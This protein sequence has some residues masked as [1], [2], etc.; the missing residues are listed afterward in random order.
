MYSVYYIYC[1]LCTCGRDGGREKQ[2]IEWDLTP[3]MLNGQFLWKVCG[4]FHMWMCASALSNK[5]TANQYL[6]SRKWLAFP[7]ISVCSEFHIYCVRRIYNIHILY[8][9]CAT[10]TKEFVILIV[11]LYRVLKYYSVKHTYKMRDTL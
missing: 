10:I 4:K 7:F 2:N 3:N 5:F 9:V 1:V 11:Y 6:P 8:M